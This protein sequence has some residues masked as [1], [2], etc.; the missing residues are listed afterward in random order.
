ME[1]LFRSKNWEIDCCKAI[2]MWLSRIYKLIT[3]KNS[4]IINVNA[5]S[6]STAFNLTIIEWNTNNTSSNEW[7]KGLNMLK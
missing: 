5:I 7:L 4:P 3:I 1:R 6:D 2:W